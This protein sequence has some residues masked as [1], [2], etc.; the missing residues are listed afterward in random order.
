MELI[1]MVSIPINVAILFFTSKGKDED[2]VIS[3]SETV[4]WFLE[5]EEGRE[6]WQVVLILIGVEHLL[7]AAK[8]V[9]A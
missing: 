3:D 6:K 5:R 8:I 9:A 2:G 1:S 7:L 4:K